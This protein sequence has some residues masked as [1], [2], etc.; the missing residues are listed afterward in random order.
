M[1]NE[2]KAGDPKPGETVLTAKAEE[3]KPGTETKPGETK[4]GEQK[5]GEENPGETTPG[6]TKPGEEKPGEQKAGEQKPGEEKPGETKPGDGKPPDKYALTL[7]DK[8]PFGEVDRTR[9]ETRA[10][11]LGLS[12]VQAQAMVDA[13]NADVSAIKTR[14]YERFA[15]DATIGGK[16]VEAS[17]ELAVKGLGASFEKAG[18]TA[19]ERAEILSMFDKGYGNHSGIIRLFR[20]MGQQFA[21]DTIEPGAG[22]GGGGGKPVDAAKQLYPGMK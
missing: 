4:P 12:Q 7:P 11:A 19:D 5:P 8:G 15:A 6:E 9:F 20:W 22:A 1:A 10:K 2:P 18:L 16:N 17:R 3:V 21:E 13:E 14:L